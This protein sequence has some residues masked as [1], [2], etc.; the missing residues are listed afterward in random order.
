M[1]IRM[2]KSISGLEYSYGFGEEI[3]IEDEKA[4][5]FLKA[6][7]AVT[8]EE[9]PPEKKVQKPASTATSKKQG[10]K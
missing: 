5:T 8:V 3:E 4:V 1:K 7:V 6:G 2:T 10:G 9:N